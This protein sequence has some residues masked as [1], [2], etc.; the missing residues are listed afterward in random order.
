MPGRHGFATETGTWHGS[1][2]FSIPPYLFVDHRGGNTPLEYVASQ[3]IELSNGF[4][5]GAG[6]DN[7]VA[8]IADSA[9]M[10]ALDSA[11]QLVGGAYRYG[12]NGQEH[13]TELS[14]DSY[15][16]EFWEYDSRTGRRWNLDPKPRVG[17]SDYSTFDGN[18]IFSSDPLG[19]NPKRG[20]GLLKNMAKGFKDGA[21]SSKE[22]IK[23]LATK[24][25]WK[26]LANGII[27][28]GDRLTISPSGLAKN[29]ESGR[30]AYEAIKNI[31]NL[32]RDDVGYGLGYG[33]E[34]VVESVLLSKGAGLVKN[35]FSATASISEVSTLY[36]TASK[37]GAA[38]NILNEGINPAFFNS[39]SR[40]GK[41]FYMSNDLATSFAELEYHGAQAV[42]TLQFSLKSTSLL[43]A[44]SPIMQIGVKY[45]PKLLSSVARGA[46]YDGIMYNSLRGG[47]LNVVQFKNFN[48]LKNGSLF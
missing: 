17:I 29:A 8:Y 10:A 11:Y 45:A 36:H 23:S 7:Y 12:F 19:D 43:N 41:G 5:T 3:T 32:T 6:S 16:A 38:A 14:N 18:P 30:S 20:A 39:A 28:V 26:N 2:A 24:Q 46:G 48:L 4:L 25:G 44:T 31:P 47:G 40:F 27:D 42:N 15:T 9:S 1:Y 22:F 37:V 21:K 13:S 33:T 34:K 35:A